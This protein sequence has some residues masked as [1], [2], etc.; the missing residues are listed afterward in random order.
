MG[1]TRRQL[2]RYIPSTAKCRRANALPDGLLRYRSKRLARCSS[3]N[4]MQ[5]VMVQGR[6]LAVNGERPALCAASLARTSAV[7]PT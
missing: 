3:E 1:C 4:S 6:Y 7:M 2:A 5:T